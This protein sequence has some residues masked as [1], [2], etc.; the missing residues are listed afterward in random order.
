MD[1]A[2][3]VR[4]HAGFLSPRRAAARQGLPKMTISCT[5][6][7]SASSL[8]MRTG[9]VELCLRTGHS[10]TPVAQVGAG[11]AVRSTRRGKSVAQIAAVTDT[12]RADCLKSELAGRSFDGVPVIFRAVSLRTIRRAE[13]V[14]FGTS[15]TSAQ[16]LPKDQW[17]KLLIDN[18]SRE[19]LLC[20]AGQRACLASP[21]R[22][23]T[24]GAHSSASPASA[25]SAT[26]L[27]R[28]E[29]CTASCTQEKRRQ[30]QFRLGG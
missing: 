24:R 27:E 16:T 12:L 30:A 6:E 14:D 13:L 8:W 1:A 2:P 29:S 28:K 23:G 17:E 4:G 26:C 7:T 11:N 5:L 18:A 20:P 21:T 10:S 22:A 19:M 15:M 3:S 25:R 9:R